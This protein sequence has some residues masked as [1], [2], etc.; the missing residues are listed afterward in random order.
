[1]A[2]RNILAYFKTPEQ[3]EQAAAQLKSMGI[4]D[5]QVDRF[6]KYSGGSEDRLINP[7]TG[8]ISSLSDLTLGDISTRDIGVLTAADVSASGMS[9]GGET[10]VS[11]RDVLVAAIV[12]DAQ[13]DQAVQIVRTGGGLV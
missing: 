12:D 2:E 9:S 10:S 11:G 13:Y 5:V 7:L 8:Q 4:G 6:S 3:A 1:M